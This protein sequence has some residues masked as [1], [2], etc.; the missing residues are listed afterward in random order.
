MSEIK[1]EEL[2]PLTSAI[3]V[4][5]DRRLFDVDHYGSAKKVYIPQSLSE[6]RA[7]REEI[8]RRIKLAAGLNPMISL[9]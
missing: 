5:T 4:V 3:H 1:K 9:P 2:L 6:H 7:R 8:I